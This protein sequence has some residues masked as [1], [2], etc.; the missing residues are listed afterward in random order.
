[1]HSRTSQHRRFYDFSAYLSD[2]KP[3]QSF[4]LCG[5]ETN[6]QTSREQEL[7]SLS[8]RKTRQIPE[9]LAKHQ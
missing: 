3:G 9:A 7:I 8:G 6:L 4:I 5:D 1:M 2:F